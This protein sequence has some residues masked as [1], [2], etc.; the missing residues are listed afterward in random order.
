M[1][2]IL[3]IVM[4]LGMAYILFIVLRGFNET[5]TKKYHDKV[6]QREKLNIKKEDEK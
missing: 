1:K 3:D 2:D 6:E 5:Q 4:P